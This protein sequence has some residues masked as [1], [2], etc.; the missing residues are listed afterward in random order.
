VEAADKHAAFRIARAAL[1]KSG[2]VTLELALAGVPTVG[3]YRVSWLEGVVGRR[4]IKVS[5]VI[6]ANLVLGENIVP[7]YI[8]EACNAESLA[9]ALTPLFED[10]S[11]RRRQVEA[12]SRL[13]AIMEIGSSAPAAR[14][15]AIVLDVAR[16]AH[17]SR[18]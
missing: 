16:R 17:A 6:L 12:F 11:Q 10:T 13:D 9:A 14:A 1:A 2:T 5:S 15:A 3:A 4:M 8:Q 18:R 7:E